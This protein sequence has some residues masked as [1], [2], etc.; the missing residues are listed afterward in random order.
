MKVSDH[1]VEKIQHESTTLS[2][3]LEMDVAK[4]IPSGLSKWISC[5]D[6]KSLA[7]TLPILVNHFSL[8]TPLQRVVLLD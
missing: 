6:R 8:L 1:F 5:H 4:S 2:N 3:Y 7:C